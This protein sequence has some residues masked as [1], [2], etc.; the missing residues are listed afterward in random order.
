MSHR[1]AV[2]TVKIHKRGD[3]SDLRLL[4][5]LD[6]GG[7]AL[8]DLLARSCAGLEVKNSDGT[9]TIR[10]VST[11]VDVPDVLLMVEHGESGVAADIVDPHG[12]LRIRQHPEDSQ[13]I[14]CGCLFRLPLTESIGW[15]AVH[16]NNNRGIKGLLSQA[17]V[18]KVRAHHPD[19]VMVITPFVMGSVLTEAVDQGRVEKIKL[20]RLE[21]PTDRVVA[22]TS[23]WVPDQEIGRLELDIS[24]RGKTGRLIPDVLRRYLHGEREVFGE[25]VEFQGMTFEQAKVEVTL[26]DGTRRTF[27]IES[28]ESGHPFTENLDDLDFAPDGTVVPGSVFTALSRSL[29]SVGH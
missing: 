13:R 6:G 27:D 23:R 21:R 10:E 18:D 2:Y 19:L 28:P 11:D 9:K 15:M 8:V 7:S 14:Q 29:G 17:L 25:I 22:A 3:P 1:A 5:D 24:A 20:V 4:G 16:V 26:G 12:A